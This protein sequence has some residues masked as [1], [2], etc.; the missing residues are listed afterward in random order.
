MIKVWNRKDDKKIK[1]VLNKADLKL[2]NSIEINE[3]TLLCETYSKIL[4]YFIKKYNLI[5]MSD[6]EE[7]NLSRKDKEIYKLYKKIEQNIERLS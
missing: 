5:V 7:I 2:L 4:K 6:I 1:D 3:N